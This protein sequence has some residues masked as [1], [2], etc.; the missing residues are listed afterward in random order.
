MNKPAAD[1]RLLRVVAIVLWTSFLGAAIATMIFFA[2]FDPTELA[3]LATF[4]MVLDHTAGYSI[5]FLAFWILLAV[6]GAIVA[7]LAGNPKLH[8]HPDNNHTLFCEQV[9]EQHK[10]E[11]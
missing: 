7:W 5:G 11:K 4:P 1:I 6:N 10:H 3:R 8:E 9:N 2:T